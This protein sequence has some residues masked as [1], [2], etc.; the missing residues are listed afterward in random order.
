MRPA[1][2]EGYDRADWILMDFFTLIVHV[3][4]PQTRDFYGLE[5]L[6]GD[7]ERI[8]MADEPHRRQKLGRSMSVIAPRRRPSVG[9]AGAA[10]R[11]LRELPSRIR[12]AGRSA[13]TAGTRIRGSRRRSCDQLRRSSALVARVLHDAGRCARA[14]SARRR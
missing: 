3:F 11:S 4:A 10:M 6:W 5:R 9:A 7:A 12:R 13:T 14:G 2:V 8:E 1:H